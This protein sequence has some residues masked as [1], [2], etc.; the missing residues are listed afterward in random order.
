VCRPE[1]SPVSL[2]QGDYHSAASHC[3]AA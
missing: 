2:L 3:S 1:L